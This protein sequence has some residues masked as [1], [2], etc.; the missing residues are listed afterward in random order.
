MSE[1]TILKQRYKNRK[2]LSN[3][4][5]LYQQ[6][7]L[8]QV[9]V[10]K[11]STSPLFSTAMESTSDFRDNNCVL[12]SPLALMKLRSGSLIKTMPNKFKFYCM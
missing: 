3:T 11:I 5:R 6:R 7:S 2:F 4:K 1:V 9:M 10:S 8:K 12:E